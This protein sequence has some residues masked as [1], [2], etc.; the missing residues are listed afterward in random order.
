MPR[1][2]DGFPASLR[3]ASDFASRTDALGRRRPRPHQGVDVRGPAGLPIIAIA[4]GQVLE[5]VTDRY[6][7]PTV[8]VDHGTTHEPL[9]ALYGHLGRMAVRAGDLVRRGD[10]IGW[11]GE[12]SVRYP[13]S[14]GIR[15]LH[16]QLGTKRRI[17]DPG[18]YY[19]HMRFLKDGRGTQSTPV[20]GR[21]AVAR[22]LLGPPIGGTCPER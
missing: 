10:P 1:Y 11:L 2:P 15:H 21:R 3:I 20:V 5:A 14:A 9:I 8:V 17:G 16:L 4:P 19:G 18:S 6:W 22:Q 12:G 7:G 13:G